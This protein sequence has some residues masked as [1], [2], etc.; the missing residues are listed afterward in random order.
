MRMLYWPAAVAGQLLQPVA[1]WHA[2]VR[3]DLSDV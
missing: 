2:Q 3:E 1:R